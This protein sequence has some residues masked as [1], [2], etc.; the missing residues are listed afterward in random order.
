MS[1]VVTGANGAGKTLNTIK[2][3]L[4]ED[5]WLKYTCPD[6]GRELPRPVYYATLELTEIA[7]GDPK[8][9]HWQSITHEELKTWWDLPPGSV[10]LIDEA[11]QFF[12]QTKG[13]GDLPDHIAKMDM[14]RHYG[15]DFILI[16]QWP[17]RISHY[18]RKILNQHYHYVRSFN[19]SQASR[20]TFSRVVDDPDDKD[21]REAVESPL[22]K[23]DKKLYKF[24]KSTSLNTRKRTLPKKFYFVVALLL[25]I[26]AFFV[27][28]AN[29]L[30][31]RVESATNDSVQSSDISQPA[32]GTSSGGILGSSTSVVPSKD[33]YL[34]ART[35]RV[36]DL[37][38][39]APVYDDVREVVTYPKIAACILKHNT[40][41]CTCYSQ[42]ATK[43]AISYKACLS[44]VAGNRVFDDALPDG[45]TNAPRQPA[46]GAGGF[47]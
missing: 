31:D 37:P 8:F 15:L 10:I 41:A 2:M 46:S 7:K 33:E 13:T 32:S 47:K 19:L 30:Y 36:A 27:Y 4:T 22:I 6:T 1:V 12:P 28:G 29:R 21:K 20:R 38:W 9:K 39:S 35:P 16:T 44:Y 45:T 26:V 18:V 3:L 42:Q 14:H 25:G 11:H 43:L 34:D 17:T 40:S 23:Y 24:Y 5:R